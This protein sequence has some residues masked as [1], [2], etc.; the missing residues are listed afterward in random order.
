MDESPTKSKK[1]IGKYILR[2]SEKLGSGYL[3]VVYKGYLLTDPSCLL[4]IKQINLIISEKDLPPLTL[5]LESHFSC[6]RSLIHENIHQCLD[7][8]TTQNNLYIISEFCNEGVLTKIQE[9]LNND[10]ILIV[11]KQIVKAMI[12]AN[13]QKLSHGDLQPK[14]I[15]IH[16][17]MIKISN[18]NLISLLSNPLFISTQKSPPKLTPLYIAPEVFYQKKSELNSD[19]WSVGVIFYELIFKR[20]PWHKHGMST[21]DLFIAI[22]NNPLEFPEER[23]IHPLVKDLLNNMLQLRKEHRYNF[24]EVLNHEL[25]NKK[26]PGKL[27]ERK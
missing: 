27:N 2:C 9:D 12:Y 4:A 15:F 7:M 25:F 23:K 16:N 22:D 3:G 19:V 18:F 6:I 24:G 26:L 14:N 5:F 13:N 10:E 21:K 17:G 1:Q 8:I 20:H 11:I